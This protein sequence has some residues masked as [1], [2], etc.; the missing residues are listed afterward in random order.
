MTPAQVEALAVWLFRQFGPVTEMWAA[1]PE[2][3]KDEWR[4][5]ARQA[6]AYTL[7]AA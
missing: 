2:H 1:Q 3:A 6:L 7:L 4:N 5:D